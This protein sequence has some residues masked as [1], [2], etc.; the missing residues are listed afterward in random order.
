M[1]TIKDIK[2][3][4]CDDVYTEL[5]AMKAR[6]D[7][8]RDNLA[9]AYGAKTEI[10]GTYDRHLLELSEQIDWKLQILSHACP[11]DW[12]GSMEYTEST[13]SVGPV[14]KIE[15]FSPGYVGG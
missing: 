5:S 4:F 8:M 7:D 10:F 12:K 11:Y 14:E 9:R 1:A 2:K 15:D 13:A 6:I 3:D